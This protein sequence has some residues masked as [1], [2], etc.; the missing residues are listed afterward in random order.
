MEI[1]PTAKIHIDTYSYNKS[2]QGNINNAVEKKEY[3]SSE[4]CL[5]SIGKAQVLLQNKTNL[6]PET[7]ADIKDLLNKIY[8][9]KGMQVG[10]CRGDKF[11]SIGTPFEKFPDMCKDEARAVCKRDKEGYLSEI[12]VL[13]HG[14]I[15]NRGNVSVYLSDGSL[16]QF[17]DDN[18][19][20]ALHEYK[21]YPECFHNTLR[22]GGFVGIQSKEEI[23]HWIET[24]DNIFS[25]DSK[26]LKTK[27]ETIVYRALPDNLSQEQIESLSTIGGVFKENSYS[28]TST[29]LNVARR[30]QRFSPILEIE[31]PVGSKYLDMDSIFNIDRERWQ[32]KEFLLPRNS[33]FEIIGYDEKNN[34]IKAKYLPNLGDVY[35]S[36]ILE[37]EDV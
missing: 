37:V 23:Q 12:W 10:F 30:F 34:V 11:I 31:L 18:D 14:G 28:S 8:E 4:N 17:F 21:Y 15:K 19:M 3:V 22:N 1:K 6:V 27:E 7:L 25:T 9:P 32:E 33:S 20:D 13:E 5:D 24:L 35:T 29:D 16:K 26:C 36:Q 2:S